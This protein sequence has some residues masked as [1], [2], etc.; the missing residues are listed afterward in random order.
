[1]PGSLHAVME[2]APTANRASTTPPTMTPG[3]NWGA[4]Q[5]ALSHQ[6]GDPIS[7]R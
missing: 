7:I 1:M 5:H 6:H 2:S 4:L 3:F